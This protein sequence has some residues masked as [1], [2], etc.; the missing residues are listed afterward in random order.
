MTDLWQS[1][2][3]CCVPKAEL[4]SLSSRRG[5]ATFSLFTPNGARVTGTPP[6]SVRLLTR[7]GTAGTEV[8]KSKAMAK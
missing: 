7:R 3:S 2:K 5:F 1:Y 6:G 4:P 8:A